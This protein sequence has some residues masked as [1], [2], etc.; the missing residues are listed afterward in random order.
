MTD[1]PLLSLCVIYRRSAETLPKLL[2]SLLLQDGTYHVDEVVLVDTGSDQ[3]LKDK[4]ESWRDHAHGL[5]V[6]LDWYACLKEITLPDGRRCI[7]DFARARNYCFSRATGKWRMFL[8]ADDE[9]ILREGFDAQRLSDWV[10]ETLE[11]P[12]GAMW[13]CVN[14]RYMYAPEVFQDR[15]CMWRWD[16]GWFWRAAIHERVE[17]LA[18][19]GTERMLICGADGPWEIQH[20][21]DT[22]S[23]VARNVIILERE[24][25]TE[26]DTELRLRYAQSL[27]ATYLAAG[28]ERGIELAATC[29]D[30]KPESGDAYIAA[31]NLSAFL[32]KRHR[33]DEALR[34]IAPM[35]AYQPAEQAGYLEMARI[36]MLKGRLGEAA[37][38]FNE[39]FFTIRGDPHGHKL[40]HLTIDV[41]VD[42]RCDAARCY[43]DCG[44]DERARAML[45]AIPM[46]H[47]EGDV[48]KKAWRDVE[49][50]IADRTAAKAVRTLTHYLIAQDEPDRAE[51]L[52]LSCIP[53]TIEKESLVHNAR[54]AVRKRMMHIHHPELYRAGYAPCEDADL[55]TPWGRPYLRRAVD[56]ISQLGA[57]TFVDVGCNTGW[58]M[59]HVAEACPECICV[60]FDVELPKLQAAERRAVEMGVRDRCAFVACPID[61]GTSA[62]DLRS[63]GFDLDGWAD[64]VTSTEVIEHVRSVPA[65]L[66]LIRWML[67]PGGTFICTTPDVEKYSVLVP[68]ARRLDKNMQ[69]MVG[70]IL[71][72]FGHVRCYDAHRLTCEMMAAGFEVV[73]TEPV[74]AFDK[75]ED[76]EVA[77][78]KLKR[79]TGKTSGDKCL[80]EVECYNPAQPELLRTQAEREAVVDQLN[81]YVPR[82]RLD[83]VCPGYV[84]WGPRCHEEGFAGGSEQAVAHLAPRLAELG[85]DVHVYAS[86]MDREWYWR[87]VWWHHCDAF[88]PMAGRSAM[89]LWRGVDKIPGAMAASKGAY[90]VL[91]WAHDV[92]APGFDEAYQLVDRVIALSPYH[93]RLFEN[94][95]CMPGRV[96]ELQNGVDAG[97]LEEVLSQVG[98]INPRAAIYGSSADRGL[99]ALLRMWPQVR[100]RVPDAELHVCYTW[101]LL[102]SPAT[103]S[104]LVGLADLCERL[105]EETEGVVSHGGLPHADFLRVAAG[106]GVWA[107]P[108]VFPEISCI[109]AM[110]MQGLGLWPV[111]TNGSALETTVLPE[112]REGMMDLERLQD[113]LGLDNEQKF[114]R[115][116]YKLDEGAYSPSF[117]QR[118]VGALRKGRNEPVRLKYASSARARYDWSRTASMFDVAIREAI[119]GHADPG[120]HP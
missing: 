28:D 52:I 63:S 15:P 74:D 41:E 99:L 40:R 95:G 36:M 10:K 71:E 60:G 115:H 83:I 106:C 26:T 44:E 34:I 57:K 100:A 88:E 98:P 77:G 6:V 1:Q 85:W 78:E 97:L 101:D 24:L 51:A 5:R 14:M 29:I 39:A 91:F 18:S 94:A 120:N 54:V 4:L 67:K 61:A 11:T 90:P 3:R 110:E 107:Y 112:F 64:V 37:A 82:G 38:F 17:R 25:E 27:S 43:V 73:K 13:N 30:F 32:R 62:H 48:V 12:M 9:L 58:L 2:E 7:G 23:S 105:C 69:H 109:V 89:M 92:P 31:C 46:E 81:A 33:L 66:K 55:G 113:E 72:K 86:P 22:E 79:W 118:L 76:V 102:R 16:D 68:F 111:T 119:S 117:L 49:N 65:Y 21:G 87:G 50:V 8:D 114:H 45:K 20:N 70:T 116:L 35:V 103:P 93:K 108:C 47:R 84:P 19:N 75:N 59:C 104:H 42:G 56:R 80:L 53:K 96:L